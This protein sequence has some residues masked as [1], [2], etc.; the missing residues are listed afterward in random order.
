MSARFT[1]L[2]LLFD[3]IAFTGYGQVAKENPFTIVANIRGLKEGTKLYLFDYDTQEYIDSAFA[4]N[5]RFTLR[6]TFRE[7]KQLAISTAQPDYHAVGF[8]WV[9]QDTSYLTGNLGDFKRAVIKGSTTEDEYQQYKTLLIPIQQKRDS[10][11][12]IKR[13]LQY[14]DSLA[15]AEV[16]KSFQTLDDEIL[17]TK[18]SF[19][20]QHPD[21][22]VGGEFLRLF[23]LTKELPKETI[24]SLYKGLSPKLQQSGS[25]Q[26]V[27]YYLRLSNNVQIGHTYLDFTQKDLAG[28]DVRVSDF[29]GKYTLLEFWSSGCVPCRAENPQLVKLYHQ[30]HPQGLEIVGVSLDVD[31]QRWKTAIE[32]DQL[33]WPQLSDLKGAYNQGAM[34]YNIPGMPSNFLIDTDGKIIGKDL[35]RDKLVDKLVEIFGK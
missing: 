1:L 25:G 17:A 34:I 32:Q 6:G 15:R 13:K 3:V 24:Q 23:T 28:Q 12:T 7:P 11:S 27:E 26:R 29:K 31:K 18:V 22:Y 8:F 30:Y 4:S 9:D 20:K 21:S 10:L 14:K 35:R 16:E 19:I 33:P 5:D 2:F